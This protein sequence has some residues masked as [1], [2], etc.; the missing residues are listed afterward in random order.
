MHNYQVVARECKHDQRFWPHGCW[1]YIGRVRNFGLEWMSQFNLR[2]VRILKA[3][4]EVWD[5]ALHL[6]EYSEGDSMERF[7]SFPTS[8]AFSLPRS[9]LSWIPY[10]HP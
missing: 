9:R 5:I 4:S 1:Y 6:D 2:A 10:L 8:C 3:I 7:G